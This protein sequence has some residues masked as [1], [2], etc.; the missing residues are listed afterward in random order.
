MSKVTTDWLNQAS[1][2]FDGS[3]TP[4]NEKDIVSRG[5]HRVSTEG[6]WLYSK[7][8]YSVFGFSWLSGIN[9]LLPNQELKKIS[10][11]SW[12]LAEREDPYHL[13]T[14]THSEKEIPWLLRDRMNQ[15]FRGTSEQVIVPLSGGYD[16]RLILWALRDISRDR[17]F[18]YT[19]GPSFPQKAS[20]E[21][22]VASQLAQKEGVF[23]QLIPVGNFRYLEPEWIEKFG[24]HTHAH[25][26]LT[27]QFFQRISEFH[28]P[29]ESVVL[30]GLVGD[31]FAGKVSVPPIQR[32]EHLLKLGY[33]H[34]RSL[35]DKDLVARPNNLDFLH[36]YFTDRSDYWD[37]PK[38]RIVELVRAKMILL[39]YLVKVPESLGFK[40][41]APLI[42]QELAM[43]M[44][45]LP[46]ERRKGRRWQADF[47]DKEGLSAK[48]IGR[49]NI[50]LDFQNLMLDQEVR[51]D[52]SN[53]EGIYTDSVIDKVQ[54]IDPSIWETVTVLS[55]IGGSKK[56][57]AAH[58]FKTVSPS[59]DKYFSSQIIAPISWYQSQINEKLILA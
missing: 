2:F 56:S 22:Q 6:L 32:K 12:T 20:R 3:K 43:S 17:I 45:S 30:S 41:E 31:A 50:S 52:F 1:V 21:A 27:M 51:F 28:D 9:Y 25:G 15:R 24:F 37:D 46:D 55:K 7:F 33:S 19:Y 35:R 10:D 57:A 44:L 49:T 18:C 16:S 40:V 8:G 39:S 38:F 42:S 11:G 26:M 23:W 58:L 53:L 59:I 48:N 5:H 13:P 36:T 14:V 54:N 4:I 34:G 29:L 47:F